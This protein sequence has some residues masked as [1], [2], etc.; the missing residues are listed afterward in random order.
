MA[1]PG[2]YHVMELNL[3]TGKKTKYGEYK[4][5]EEAEESWK[6]CMTNEARTE[7]E[8]YLK[9]QRKDFSVSDFIMK[10][11]G[12]KKCANNVGICKCSENMNE[13]LLK[14][15]FESLIFNKIVPKSSYGWNI[16]YYIVYIV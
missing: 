11:V 6:M 3:H 15:K 5:Y 2:Y 10:T 4:V 14:T 1:D 8:E 9:N 12:C 16:Y 13:L 7:I